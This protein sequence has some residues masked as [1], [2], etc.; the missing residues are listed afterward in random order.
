[1][2][3]NN[4]VMLRR[5]LAGAL[6]VVSTSGF[7]AGF[8]SVFSGVGPLVAVR[9]LKDTTHI[10]GLKVDPNARENVIAKSSEV[11]RALEGIPS[12]AQYRKDTE[13]IYRSF[14]NAAK[15]SN[16]SDEEVSI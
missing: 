15:D 7:S 12:S 6:Q 10:V 8:P 14:I 13:A 5:S 3:C 9:G 16:L 4:R 2:F 1:M 11:L